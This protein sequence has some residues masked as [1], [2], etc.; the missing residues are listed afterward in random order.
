LENN[1]FFRSVLEKLSYGFCHVR[2]GHFA[3][4][5]A[6]LPWIARLSGAQSS[7][8]DA[9]YSEHLKSALPKIQELYLQD[10]KNIAHGLYPI[11][12]LTPE[13]PI[14]H[15]SRIPLLYFD[16]FR[17]GRQ[18]KKKQ[19]KKFDHKAQDLFSELPGY[20]KRNF[21]YQDSGYLGESSAELYEHQVEVL[22]SGAADAMRRILIA[23]LKKH[24]S[25]SDGRG[26]H[27]LEVGCG[28]GRLTKFIALAFPEAKVTAVDLSPFYI[29][30]ATRQLNS[31]KKIN[32][33]HG[34]AENLDFKNQ[35][36]DAILSCYLFHEL[37]EGV[38]R[39][40]LKE[41]FRLLKPG[42]FYAV[43]DSLQKN[44][45][46]DLDWALEQFPKDFHEP[47]YKNYILNPLDS[48]LKEAGFV[49]I[50]TA[51]GFLTKAVTGKKALSTKKSST[52]KR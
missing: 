37:P 5:G 26:L 43:A 21:H 35:T 18:K 1:I 51:K 22:F 24:F 23:P 2:S 40:V 42:G 9:S 46:Q 39:Q 4:Q 7:R 45:D 8:V 6:L 52:K 44:D 30:S 31:L 27:F 36:F 17:A 38:R 32:F 20:Y 47:F 10:S 33:V 13:N 28:T 25:N 41:G 34:A 12:V 16:A 19:T 50:S 15:F 48:L 14:R 3:W 11:T 29:K 49:Q